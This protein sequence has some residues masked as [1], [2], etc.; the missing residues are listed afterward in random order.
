MGDVGNSGF[1]T[2]GNLKEVLGDSFNG[3]SME[4]LIKEADFEKDGRISYD[5]FIRYLQDV[6]VQANPSGAKAAVATLQVIDKEV[7]K[8]NSDGP[9][10]TPTDIWK[11]ISREFSPGAASDSL[12]DYAYDPPPKRNHSKGTC[13]D[14]AKSICRLRSDN[15]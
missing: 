12:A 10:G 3:A 13:T 11:Q 15:V 1:I 14:A 6:D 8:R 5:E 7:A 9:P 2:A 4:E